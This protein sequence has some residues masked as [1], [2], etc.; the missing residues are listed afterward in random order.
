MEA[1]Q[2]TPMAEML[3]DTQPTKADMARAFVREY[4]DEAVDRQEIPQETS[5][6]DFYKEIAG[7]S[8]ADI[9]ILADAI[10]KRQIEAQLNANKKKIQIHRPASNWKTRL[11]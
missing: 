4:F 3:E 5:K 7:T 1:T 11:K 6:E 8:D 10:R 2:V 9:V